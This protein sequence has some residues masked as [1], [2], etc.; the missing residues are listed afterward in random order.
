MLTDGGKVLGGCFPVVS[1]LWGTAKPFN[2]PA[3]VGQTI[4]KRSAMERLLML[5]PFS[6]S[7]RVEAREAKQDLVTI[8]YSDWAV[9]SGESR[10]TDL[11]RALGEG[12]RT[13]RLSESSIPNPPADY[14]L[15]NLFAR[16]PEREGFIHKIELRSVLPERDAFAIP[17]AR[18]DEQED[19]SGVA[20]FRGILKRQRDGSLLRLLAELQINPTRYAA[21]QPTSTALPSAW[22]RPRLF[23]RRAMLRAPGEFVLG[24]PE[25]R[26]RFFDNVI[27][28]QR[29]MAFCAPDRWLLHV[30][31][32]WQ[33]IREALGFQIA[34]AANHLNG[35][36][37]GEGQSRLQIRLNQSSILKLRL[38]ETY[39][40]FAAEDPISLVHRLHR[41]LIS[42]ARESVV[43]GYVMRPPEALRDRNS[44][45]VTLYL[46]EGLSL[47]VY[48]KTNRRVRWE[49]VHD[50]R[51]NRL[52]ASIPGIA[53]ITSSNPEQ[54]FTWLEACAVSAAE[55]V[56]RVMEY[57]ELHS[58]QENG[59]PPIGVTP[60]RL[61]RLIS[62]AAE[63]EDIAEFLLEALCEE[64]SV[65]MTNK[66][67]FLSAA[68]A[69]VAAG[70]LR[71]TGVRS[72]VLVLAPEYQSV[73]EAIREGRFR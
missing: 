28:S 43:R 62:D 18:A 22:G 30:R 19:A 12:P 63:S 26:D 46:R 2:C 47:R 21:Y 4:S 3:L 57:L 67:P 1:I 20:L 15:A 38:V 14:H 42:Y 24:D 35:A 25:G 17:G 48:A 58:G 56:N 13:T 8:E 37:D 27:L 70:V 16:P 72:K 45:S 5:V 60:Y 23:A 36:R 50:F 39:F 31:R 71:R 11:F 49:V 69:L 29:R 9:A 7:N 44:P 65:V 68:R 32:Y 54:L 55:E 66:A 64:Q 6:V 40:E 52:R 59:Q 41:L 10:I 33:T 61:L 53:T 51:K 34:V 73:V